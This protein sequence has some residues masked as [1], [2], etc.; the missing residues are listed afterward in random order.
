MAEIVLLD[1]DKLEVDF[2]CILNGYS[3]AVPC[4]VT[5]ILSVEDKKRKITLRRN[6][7][8]ITYGEFAR[9]KLE[10][11]DPICVEPYEKLSPHLSR[12]VLCS[13]SETTLIAA[14]TIKYK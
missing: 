3:A 12:I 4:R 9:V 10:P 11:E 7:K 5:K 1:Q 14:G 8:F 13:R 6:P 2:K